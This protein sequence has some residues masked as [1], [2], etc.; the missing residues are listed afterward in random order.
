MLK[1]YD[2]AL[3]FAE[4]P[5]EVTLAINISSCPHHCKN[6]HSQ[7]LQKD[8][9]TSLNVKNLMKLIAEYPDIT[10]VCFMGGDANH[11]HI[12]YL[13]EIIHSNTKLKV[14]MYSGDDSVDD[15]LVAVLDYYKVGSYQEDKGPLTKE[16]TN[17]R[18]YSISQEKQLVDITYK[19]QRKI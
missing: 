14:A 16:T 18:L 1:Y 2:Y 19:M 13:S 17:Q 4:I 12:V 6:C 3:V 9:G 10:C 5:D 7:W 15:R 8:I 11:E